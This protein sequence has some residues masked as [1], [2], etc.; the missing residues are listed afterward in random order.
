MTQLYSRRELYE[1]G[2]LGMSDIASLNYTRPANWDEPTQ[3]PPLPD[4]IGKILV[5]IDGSSHSETGLSHAVRLAKLAKAELLV[6]VAFHPPSRLHRRGL[7]PPEE[8][9]QAMEAD[10]K[11]LAGEAA[12]LLQSKGIKVRAMAV[13]GD[14]SE[15]I[16]G[17][18]ED[19]HVDL[20]VMGRRGVQG[21]RGML[22]GSVSERVLRHSEIPVMV[23]S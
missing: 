8:I 22:L 19:E 6:M 2:D 14:P 3:L 21:I 10:A 18:S 16:I 20:I 12:Q 17:V 11:E 13:R 7:L 5:P 1:K 15:A 9:V 23:V 4:K